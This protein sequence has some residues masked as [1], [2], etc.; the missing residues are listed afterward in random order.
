MLSCPDLPLPTFIAVF[1]TLSL[2]N[3][4]FSLCMFCNTKTSLWY[5]LAVNVA[6]INRIQ[7]KHPRCV[8]NVTKL[9]REACSSTYRM[10][11]FLHKSER[12]SNSRH[13]HKETVHK[14]VALLAQICALLGRH[15]H[16]KVAPTYLPHHRLIIYMNLVAMHMFALKYMSPSFRFGLLNTLHGTE[17]YI[18]WSVSMALYYEEHWCHDRLSPRLRSDMNGEAVI[19]IHWMVEMLSFLGIFRSFEQNLHRIWN[20]VRIELLFPFLND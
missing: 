9:P 8:F 1:F 10:C 7:T 5:H 4:T 19:K 14:I 11:S 18:A 6:A 15:G 2:K 16:V 20:L 3:N 13:L 17:S 12:Y